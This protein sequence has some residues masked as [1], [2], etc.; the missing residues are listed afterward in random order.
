MKKVGI[1]ITEA[2]PEL[3]TGV[4]AKA[5]EIEDAWIKA[6]SAKGIDAAKVLAEFRAELKNV[7]AGK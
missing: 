5:R 7:A 6:A 3:I 1:N 2:S 4:Q